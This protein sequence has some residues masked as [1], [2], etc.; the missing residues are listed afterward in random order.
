MYKINLIPIY[1]ADQ[2]VDNFIDSFCGSFGEICVQLFETTD[3]LL[4]DE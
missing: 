1:F 2:G 3:I 4:I